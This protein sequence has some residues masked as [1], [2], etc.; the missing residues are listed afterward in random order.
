MAAVARELL[1]EP[2]VALSS[3]AEWRYGARGSLSVDVLKGTFC[4][5]EDGDR[6]GG[7]IELAMREKRT[8]KAGALSWLVERG[9]IPER[10]KTP[11]RIGKIVAAYDYAAADGTLLFQ[12]VRFDPKDFRQRVPDGRGGWAWLMKGVN[13]VLYRLPK[14]LE[15]VAAERTI[16]VAE[17]E[18]AVHALETIGMVGTCS[19][20]GAGKWKPAYSAALAGAD[21]V[22]LPDNDAPGRAHAD[23]VARALDGIA[24]QV[25]VVALPGLSEKGDVADW[26]AAGGTTAELVAL[27]AAAPMP[28]VGDNADDNSAPAWAQYLQLDEAQKAI[29]NLANAMTT[30][31]CAEELRDCFAMDEMLRAPILVKRLPKGVAGDTLRPVRDGDVSQVQEWMQRHDLRRI[32]KDVVHQAVDMRAD[33]RAFHPVRDYLSALQWDSTPRL[34]SW[35]HVY[36]GAE[37]ADYSAGIGTMFLIAMVA[38]VMRPG[39][40]CDYMMVLEGEQGAR[41]STACAILGGKWF[42]DNLPDIRSGKDVSQHLNGKWLIEVA[43]MSALDKAEAAALKAFITRGEER[44]RPSYGRK[45]VIEPRQCVFI[46]TTNKAVYLRDET[47]GRRFWPVKVGKIDTDKLRTDR[48]QLFAEAVHLYRA[49]RSWWP[50]ADF[51]ADHIRPQQDARYESDAWEDAIG[52]WL[53]TQRS[54][55]ILAVARDGLRIE[56]PKIGTADQRRIAAALERLGWERRTS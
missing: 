24:K 48:D 13:R 18:K 20:G 38:R 2:N 32:G 16:F 53:Q 45:E 56:T 54:V 4:D 7:V 15:A 14:V 8:D 9:H 44:Y 1:G 33:E 6:G 19:P 51:E 49:G 31:R 25:T 41:K 10:E 29:P 5:H 30:L 27:V 23:Q 26:V 50:H 43:E 17:G 3:N 55:T 46:G 39:V 47:G 42:S 12:V 35:L 34:Y 40:K 36:L 37:L 52:E 21:V 11:D 28:Q 22:I